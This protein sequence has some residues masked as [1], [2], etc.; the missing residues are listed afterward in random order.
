MPSNVAAVRIDMPGQP[1]IRPPNTTVRIP[2]SSIDCHRYCNGLGVSMVVIAAPQVL[3]G[4]L[5]CFRH[6]SGPNRA[7]SHQKR[8]SIAMPANAAERGVLTAGEL[9]AVVTMSL[10]G[11]PACRMCFSSDD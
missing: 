10:F 1:R 3:R 5:R 11:S 9:D 2:V 6:R 4:R 8:H 7:K